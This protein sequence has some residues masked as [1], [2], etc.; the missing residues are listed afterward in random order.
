M[1][2][3]SAVYEQLRGQIVSGGYAPGDRLTEVSVGASLAV[4]RTPVREALRRLESDGLV[5]STGRGVVVVALTPQAL[6]DAFAV[7]A[8]L[9]ALTAES[10]ADRQRAGRIAPAAL[11]ELEQAAVRLEEVT[12]AGDLGQAIELNRRFHLAVAELAANPIALEILDRLWNRIVIS[13]RASLTAPERPEV[14]AAEHR[15]LLRAIAQGDRAAAGSAAAGHVRGTARQFGITT[16][17]G[18]A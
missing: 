8:V 17:E 18:Q 12:A 7:R 14:V 16:S 15:E 13:T 3:G 9:E 11:A 1:Q 5:Q 10:A 6:E 4:S 2:G